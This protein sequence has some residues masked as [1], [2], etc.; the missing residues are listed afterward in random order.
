MISANQCASTLLDGTTRF[1][2]NSVVPVDRPV[3]SL[4]LAELYD[5]GDASFV[6]FLLQYSGTFKPVIGLIEKWKKDPRPWARQLKI[7]FLLRRDL[8]AN[9]RVVFKRLFKH[10]W[11]E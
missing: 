4:L 8:H 6:K 9:V 7:D 2:H 11:A 3:S 10:A 5:S 1:P